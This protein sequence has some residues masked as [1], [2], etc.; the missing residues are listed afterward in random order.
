[1]ITTLIGLLIVMPIVVGFA[2]RNLTAPPMR[3]HVAALPRATT[4]P[5]QAAPT[6]EPLSN[7]LEHPK[8]HGHDHGKHDHGHHHHG[9]KHDGDQ[10]EN[11]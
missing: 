2:V 7:A 4:P 3:Q 9:P 8:P 1:V 11:D 6:L 5:P 10:N